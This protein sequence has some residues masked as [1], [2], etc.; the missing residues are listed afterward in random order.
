M[1]SP[2]ASIIFTAIAGLFVGAYSPT[3][4]IL[5]A[6]YVRQWWKGETRSVL[7]LIGG[8]LLRTYVPIFILGIPVSLAHVSGIDLDKLMESNDTVFLVSVN[9]GFFG[10]LALF[11]FAYYRGRQERLRM[12]SR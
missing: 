11:A 4:I 8:I 1:I 5:V 6:M 10:S 2:T 3:W 9:V 7:R 12:Q